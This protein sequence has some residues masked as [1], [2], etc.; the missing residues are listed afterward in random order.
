MNKADILAN[1]VT[2]EERSLGELQ[3]WLNYA[4][5]TWSLGA[6]IIWLPYSLIL[7]GLTCFHAL[8]TLAL[9]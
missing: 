2:V 5:H 3:Y 7:M 8:Y 4:K 1:A 6:G 9:I